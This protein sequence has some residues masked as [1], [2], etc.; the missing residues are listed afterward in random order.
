[1][2][3]K[4]LTLLT[5]LL[6]LLGN[7]GTFPII[8]II[9]YHIIVYMYY[10]VY[11]QHDHVQCR[12]DRGFFCNTFFNQ[13]VDVVDQ[14]RWVDTQLLFLGLIGFGVLGVIGKLCPVHL[15]PDELF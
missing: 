8:I 2:S 1:M 9:I 3:W 5:L 15:L 12:T 10:F 11:W 13:T 6:L 4:A 7:I 14:P